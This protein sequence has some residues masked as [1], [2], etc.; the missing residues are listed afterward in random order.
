MENS[1]D[2]V[3]L[4]WLHGWYSQYVLAQRG[5]E[6]PLA[7]RLL[8]RHQKVGFDVFDY[9]IIKRRVVEGRT[10]EHEDWRVGHPIVFPNI[11]RVGGT[12]R[13]EFEFRVPMD[14]THTLHYWYTCYGLPPG[15]E[16]PHYLNPPYYHVP[17]TD[18]HGWHIVDFVDGQDLM[19]WVTQ[20]PIADREVEH[21]GASDTGIALFRRLLRENMD[22]IAAGD[23]P[24]NVFR[25]PGSD[26]VLE[27]AQEERNEYGRLTPETVTR[28]QARYSPAAEELVRAFTRVA[29]PAT[30]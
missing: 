21:L 19:A 7:E 14:D 27:I 29:V 8:R 2:P 20:G 25:G 4:E 1:L 30:A 24:M 5:E 15:A 13:Y 6:V 16:V 11:L 26:R 12:G 28:F 9:G 3:H 17:I 22:R 18:E 10:E 23:D